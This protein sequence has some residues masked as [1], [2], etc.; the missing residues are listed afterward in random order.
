MLREELK[1][2]TTEHLRDTKQISVR[3]ANCCASIGLKTLYNIILYFENNGTFFKKRIRR[4]GRTTCEELDKFCV[5]VIPKI[6]IKKR[7][8]KIKKVFEVINELTEQE[9]EILLSLTNLIGETENIIKEKEKIFSKHCKYDFSFAI[10]FYL[11]NGHFPMFWILEQHIINNRSRELDIFTHSFNIIQNR[12]LLSKREIAEKYDLT[13]ERVRQI[14]YKTF[15]KTFEITDDIIEYKTNDELLELIPVLQ[16]KNDWAYTLEF[17]RDTHFVNQKKS[18]IQ[19]Y[20]K[21]EQCNLSVE[22]VLQIIAYLFHDTFSLFGG[23]EIS[24]RNRIW[25]NTF[26]IKKEFTDIFNFEKFKIEFA[27]HIANNKKEY[28]LIIDEFLSNS[29]CWTS[30]IDLSKLDSIIS[31]VKDILLY[32]FYLYSNPDGL[33]TVNTTRQRKALYVVYE[34]LKTKGEPMHI[35]D[36]FAEFKKILPEHKYTKVVQ[37]R[38]YLQR[39]KSIL[40]KTRSGIYTLKE[41]EH[42]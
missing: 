17:F 35:D 21:K 30:I 36:I 24:N 40:Y 22:F 3:A 20:L 29:A 5:S 7:D 6:E 14:C 23:I 42:D 38:K 27:N 18:E 26:L 13:S 11:S 2:I 39:L 4:A 37:L 41:W 33:I 28:D 34:I 32:E 9:R 31:I 10:D 8:V 12:Q 16:S 19:E 1:Y 15:R 25:K